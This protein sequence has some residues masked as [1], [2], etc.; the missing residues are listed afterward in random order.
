MK[1]KE[2]RDIWVYI[3]TSDNDQVDVIERYSRSAVE[4]APLTRPYGGRELKTTAEISEQ[5]GRLFDAYRPQYEAGKTARDEAHRQQW[6]SI[7]A[8]HVE[9]GEDT[10]LDDQIIN[11]IDR[12]QALS[13]KESQDHE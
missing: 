9:R 6:N 2:K 8:A 10:R 3:Y 1:K 12:Q 4:L 5:M 7:R 13:E 11:I